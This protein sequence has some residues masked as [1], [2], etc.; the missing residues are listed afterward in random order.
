[1]I[2]SRP[3]IFSGAAFLQQHILFSKIHQPGHIFYFQLAEDIAAMGVDG[4][5]AEEKL[6]S[7]FFGAHFPA[8]LL[9]IK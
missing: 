4:K 7:N 2:K 8:Y 1:M 3:D 6:G 5:V 9:G